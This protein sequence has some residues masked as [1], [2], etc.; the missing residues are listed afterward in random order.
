MNWTTTIPLMN[1]FSSSYMDVSEKSGTPQIIHLDRVFHYKPSILGYPYF[2]KH[3]YNKALIKPYFLVGVPL[4]GGTPR[5]P[6]WPNRSVSSRKALGSYAK[7]AKT[8]WAW[9]PVSCFFKNI[10]CSSIGGGFLDMFFIFARIWGNDL[11]WPIYFKW[12]EI[13]NWSCNRNA[14]S[15]CDV[16]SMVQHDQTNIWKFWNNRSLPKTD[17]KGLDMLGSFDLG[18][19]RL[20]FSRMFLAGLSRFQIGL[21]WRFGFNKTIKMN[22]QMTFRLERPKVSLTNGSLNRAASLKDDDDDDGRKR[23]A[24]AL[25]LPMM[26]MMVIM[27]MKIKMILMMMTMVSMIMT[28]LCD[29]LQLNLTIARGNSLPALS[30]TPSFV[31]L[32]RTR[33]SQKVVDNH[34][35]RFRKRWKQAPRDIL[36]V[37]GGRFVSIPFHNLRWLWFPFSKLLHDSSCFRFAD[38]FFFRGIV[39]SFYKS[40]RWTP[41]PLIQM[42]WAIRTT[43]FSTGSKSP[44]NLSSLSVKQQ[45]FLQNGQCQ[46]THRPLSGVVAEQLFFFGRRGSR[47]MN[48]NHC[49]AVAWGEVIYQDVM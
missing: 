36:D 43:F 32:G 40:F 12:V 31:N 16:S 29:Y 30:S 38:C 46:A 33:L 4:G 41:S 14:S 37:L 3:P 15:H 47:W 48:A 24:L 5:F 22:N 25:L 44:T 34:W 8:G 19:F 42:Q 26:K 18:K 28:L 49:S 35:G 10:F 1:H 21:T 9:W 2:W 23:T 17:L 45:N 27:M 7:T 13:T 20:V 6:W 39:L 11:F